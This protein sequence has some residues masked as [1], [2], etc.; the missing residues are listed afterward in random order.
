MSVVPLHRRSCQLTIG[1]ST[2]ELN[3]PFTESAATKY[4]S[5]FVVAQGRIEI[6]TIRMFQHPGLVLG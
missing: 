6:P 5:T 1:L 3:L 2:D 4:K